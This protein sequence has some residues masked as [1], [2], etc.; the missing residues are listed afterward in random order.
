M[1]QHNCSL[2]FDSGGLNRPFSSSLIFSIESGFLS[3]Q[4]LPLKIST[5][6]SGMG[7]PSASLKTHHL[8]IGKTGTK[9]VQTGSSS[10]IYGPAGIGSL[11]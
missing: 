5:V 11:P 4:L 7:L 8:S 10:R 6:A 2:E 9:F 1:K 3:S